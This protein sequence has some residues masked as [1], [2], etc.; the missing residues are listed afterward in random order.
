[1]RLP[2]IDSATYRAIV[3]ALQTLAAF[4]I[5]LGASPEA[6]KLLTDFY[7]TV[8]PT[9]VAGAGLAS[10]VLNIFRKSVKNY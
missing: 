6:M 9:V 4:L 5:A 2:K 10:L 3:T 1:M 8:V 7:P